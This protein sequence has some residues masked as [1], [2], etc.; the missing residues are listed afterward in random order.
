[1][2][3]VVVPTRCVAPMGAARFSVRAAAAKP[4][5]SR[6]VQPC[7]SWDSQAYEGSVVRRSQPV[8]AGAPARVAAVP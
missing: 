7:V 1:M 8:K 5:I 4:R 3:V 2:A 6:A